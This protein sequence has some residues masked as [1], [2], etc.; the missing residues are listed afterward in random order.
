M[1]PQQLRNLPPD[2][3]AFDCRRVDRS[4][5]TTLPHPCPLLSRWLTKTHPFSLHLTNNYPLFQRTGRFPSKIAAVHCDSSP[6]WKDITYKIMCLKPVKWG[7]THLW[8][9]VLRG[10]YLYIVLCRFFPC[11]WNTDHHVQDKQFWSW[12]SSRAL[13]RRHGSIYQSIEVSLFKSPFI[14][15]LFVLKVLFHGSHV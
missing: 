14:D 5:F 9:N 6:P 15:N 12:K 7:E 10:K 11:E 13:K 8:R 1:W 4:S 2:T 3:T